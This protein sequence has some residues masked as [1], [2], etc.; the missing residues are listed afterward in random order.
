MI[1]R[2]F[3]M[4]LLKSNRTENGKKKIKVTNKACYLYEED[5]V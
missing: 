1:K 2:L 3:R 4:W 5:N